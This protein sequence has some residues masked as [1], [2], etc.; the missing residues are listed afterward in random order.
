MIGIMAQN[1]DVI[2]PILR[3]V[4]KRLYIT[5][6][7]ITWDVVVLGTGNYHVELYYTCSDADVGS[8]VELT[9]GENKITEIVSKAY[10]L[11]LRGMENDRI[12]RQESYVMGFRGT[13][14]TR[15]ESS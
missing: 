6:D 11:P 9:F 3:N 10:D 2:N 14:F 15:V 12:E 4:N 8:T 1:I 5:F 7:S 13:L